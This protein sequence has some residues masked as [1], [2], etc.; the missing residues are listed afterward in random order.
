M[1]K[2]AV[3]E[4]DTTAANN[5]D[6]NSID[7]DENCA[8]SGINNAIRENMAQ[9]A[10]AMTTGALTGIGHIARASNATIV[11]ADRGKCN[12]CSAALTLDLTAAATMGVG[13]AGF[14]KADGGDVIVDPN[15]SET[16]EGASTLTVS[17][18]TTALIYTDA[19]TWYVAFATPVAS[20]D[21]TLAGSLDYLTISGQEITRNAIDLATDT[22][23]TIN[24]TSQVTGALPVANGGTNRASNTA[25][26]IM[27]A[28]STATGTLQNIVP[29]VAGRVLTSNGPS[30]LATFQDSDTGAMELISTVTASNDG[31]VTFTGLSSTYFKYIVEI[32][33]LL[34]A[35][36]NVEFRMRTSTNNG[37][38]YDGSTNDYFWVRNEHLSDTGT[39]SS[40]NESGA[41]SAYILLASVVGD[42]AGEEAAGTINILNPSAAN[43]CNIKWDFSSIDSG[44]SLLEAR[45]SARRMAAANVDA[46]QFYFDTGNISTGTFKLYGLRAS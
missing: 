43:H 31:T 28:G 29:G 2:T 11:K 15:G 8:P 35:G 33:D 13:W 44:D 14:V 4:W 30:A 21:V 6:I 22:T 20:T 41:D 45:G 18:G 25:Y 16:I 34:P 12:D 3:T 5:T 17:D 23:G 26:A 40:Q 1:A 10:T 38:S 7:I 19:T 46:I 36:N 32:A 39:T 42:D 37:S 24:L 27:A 9:I